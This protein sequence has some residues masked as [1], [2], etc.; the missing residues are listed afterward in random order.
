MQTLNSLIINL[1]SQ[2]LPVALLVR[3]KTQSL[4]LHIDYLQGKNA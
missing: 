4:L 3:V 2:S 1:N